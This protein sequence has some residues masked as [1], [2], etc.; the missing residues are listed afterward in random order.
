M[1]QSR[2]ASCPHPPLRGTLSHARRA[3]EGLC[4]PFSRLVGEGG[5]EGRMRAGFAQ[6]YQI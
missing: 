1:R 4:R 5:P 6:M 2:V 3:G